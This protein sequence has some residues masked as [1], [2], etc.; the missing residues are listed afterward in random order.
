LAY[1]I[2]LLQYD[3][4]KIYFSEGLN[5][6]QDIPR[7]DMLY[8]KVIRICSRQRKWDLAEETFNHFKN[9]TPELK[10]DLAQV[11]L[12]A[13]MHKKIQELGLSNYVDYESKHTILAFIKG[14]QNRE[15]AFMLLDTAKSQF[16]IEE[17]YAHKAQLMI[18]FEMFDELDELFESIKRDELSFGRFLFE[19]L[20]KFYQHR[21]LEKDRE[22]MY[23]FSLLKLRLD[24]KA[25]TFVFYEFFKNLN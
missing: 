15:E 8:C 5:N 7:L 11:Y 1:S 20:L 25:D 12:R 2:I 3:N 6:P 13:G 23:Y 22:K 10:S 19:D 16:E 17:F 18:R 24:E 21:A 9:P 4:G 14:T